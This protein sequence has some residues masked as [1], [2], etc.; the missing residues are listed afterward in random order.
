MRMTVTVT[1]AS[2]SAVMSVTDKGSAV[3]SNSETL[4]DA[5]VS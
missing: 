2:S 1:A 4:K 5:K 3:E